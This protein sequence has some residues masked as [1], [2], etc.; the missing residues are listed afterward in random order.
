MK[1]E[2]IRKKKLKKKIQKKI[3]KLKYE[4]GPSLPGLM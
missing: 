3:K 4:S 1:E 2:K